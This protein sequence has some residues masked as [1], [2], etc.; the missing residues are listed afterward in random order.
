M[1]SSEVSS[2]NAHNGVFATETLELGTLTQP[3]D[4]AKAAAQRTARFSSACSAITPSVDEQVHVVD[5]IAG[6]DI[7]VQAESGPA[8][9]CQWGNSVEGG[10][11]GCHVC[12]S[13]MSVCYLNAADARVFVFA[14]CF[15]ALPLAISPS[16]LPASSF[17]CCLTS[18][19]TYC[20]YLP[21][22]TST[23]RL[24]IHPHSHPPSPLL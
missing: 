8:H 16:R 22:F 5:G 21:T 18:V 12:F 15:E 13:T 10:A 9:E 1:S 4:S 7:V 24:L 17:T 11:S 6:I 2:P 14:V 20:P 23:L 19:T 3:Y